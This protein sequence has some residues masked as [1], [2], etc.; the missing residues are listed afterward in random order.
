MDCFDYDAFI[1]YRHIALDKAIAEKLQKLLEAYRPPKSGEYINTPRIRKVFRDESELPTSGDLGQDIRQ[2]LEHSAYLIVICSEETAKSKWCMQEIT[3]FKELHGGSTDR[4]LTLLVSGE[5]RLVFPPELCFENRAVH[6]PDGTEGI[7][8]FDVEPLAANVSAP[9]IKGSLRKLKTEFLRIAAPILGCGYD[10]LYRRHQRRLFRNSAVAAAA[11]ILVLASFSSFAYSQY[12]QISR[13]ASQIQKQNGEIESAYQTL[14]QTNEQ[15]TTVNEELTAQIAETEKQRSAAEESQQEANKQA[16]LAHKSEQEAL[17]NLELANRNEQ[18]A[19]SNLAMANRQRAL[20]LENENRAVNNLT[21]AQEQQLFRTVDYAK[22]LA[23]SGDRIQAA[24]ILS[25]AYDHFNKNSAD[26]PAFKN[27][28]ET[29]MGSTAYYPAYTPYFK[30]ESLGG[31]ITASVFSEDDSLCA[32]AS[33]T[34][35]AVWDCKSG[36]KLGQFQTESPISAL[37]LYRDY[38]I[39][40]QEGVRLSV[41]NIKT[42][43]LVYDETFYHGTYP[44]L[45]PVGQI[46]CNDTLGCLIISQ[47]LS[48][49]FFIS[50]PWLNQNTGANPYE[51]PCTGIVISNNGRYAAVK[52]SDQLVCI[53]LNR[54][55]PS[56]NGMDNFKAMCVLSFGIPWNIS[57]LDYQ[58]N[59]HGMLYYSIDY[60]DSATNEWVY[61]YC[62]YDLT[63]PKLLQSYQ[64]NKKVTF[65]L[66][67]LTDDRC[68]YTDSKNAYITDLDDDTLDENPLLDWEPYTEDISASCLKGGSDFLLTYSFS[69]D[70]NFIYDSD[71]SLIRQIDG[72]DAPVSGA[73][74]S[75]DGTTFLLC[76]KAGT[77]WLAGNEAIFPYTA[78]CKYNYWSEGFSGTG[79]TVLTERSLGN[80]YRFQCCSLSTGAFLTPL[81]QADNGFT[82]FNIGPCFLYGLSSYVNEKAVIWDI[83][84]GA[85]ASPLPALNAQKFDWEYDKSAISPDFKTIVTLTFN[86]VYVYSVKEDRFTYVFPI[87]STYDFVGVEDDGKTVWLVDD[88]KGSVVIVDAATGEILKS[89]H[90]NY[91]GSYIRS[92][93]VNLQ[94]GRVLLNASLAENTSGWDAGVYSLESGDRILSLTEILDADTFEWLLSPDAT[95][96]RFNENQKSSIIHIPGFSD[97]LADT[98]KLGAGR[99]LTTLERRDSGLSIFDN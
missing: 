67:E 66:K 49:M 73:A 75:H 97:I 62:F 42:D 59:S 70:D 55:D 53:D 56:R 33:G 83:R 76:S 79:V 41:W 6:L 3:Y 39:V 18:D 14:E 74:V 80:P 47:P 48:K 65:F 54:F 58:I 24:A 22:L 88:R 71:G 4:I 17:S 19:L 16:A 86:D 35:A 43:S 27:Q 95:L 52:N 61:V 34:T 63:E 8:A 94:E 51:L 12:L 82:A 7:E 93:Y 45:C 40:G 98:R 20:A 9:T 2:A 96:A 13:Q 68:V 1:S 57:L 77:I 46:A 26:F 84:T 38:L 15:L 31:E 28:M 30:S 85:I 69:K 92:L 87:S 72:I 44:N 37:C 50:Y 36:Q 11:V 32:A 29:A 60:Q 90:L 25:E 23:V 5:P 99:T 81:A 78:S 91:P 21:L 64:L 10:D 89:R